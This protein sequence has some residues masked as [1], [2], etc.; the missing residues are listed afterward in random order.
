MKEKKYRIIG[1]TAIKHWFPDF[2]REPKDIDVL[3]DQSFNKENLPFVTDKRIEI[4][5]NPILVNWP[6]TNYLSPEVLLT[7]KLSHL[8]WDIKWEKHMWDAQYL[9]GKGITPNWNLF[10]ILYSHWNDTHPN[11]RSNLK[12]SKED[13]FTNAVNYDE[14]EHDYIHSL[15]NPNPMFQRVLKDNCEVELDE[16]KYKSLSFDEKLE[17][18][19]EEVYVMAWERYRKLDYRIA[20]SKMLKKFIINHVPLFA[21]PF[22]LEN[23]V[24]LLRPK[25]NFIE[26]IDSALC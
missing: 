7:L 19:R 16:N 20:F 3:A 10:W 6:G 4:L 25:Y 21:L 18:I 1:S 5:E 26:K 24:T 22:V 9:L 11:R 23:Y 2:P 12:Q 14:H 13:F 17:F 15:I 8:C